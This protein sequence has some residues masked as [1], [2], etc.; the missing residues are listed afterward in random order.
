MELTV[1]SIFAGAG[2]SSLGYK[3]AGFKELLAIEWDKN[4]VETFKLNFPEVPVWQRDIREV[5]A[6]EILE[7]CKIKKGELDVLDGSPPCQG[8]STAGKRQ[9]SDERNDLFLPYANLIRGLQ[10]KIFVME[11]VSGLIKGKMKGKFIEIMIIL[12][13][14]DY[15]VKCKLMNA[16]YYQVPQSRERLIWIGVRKD[17]GIKPSYSEPSKKIIMIREA[18]KNCPDGLKQ[19]DFTGKRLELSKKI[20]RW[21]CGSDI[22]TGYSFNLKRLDW[23]KPSRTIIKQIGKSDSNYGGGLIHPDK[24]RHLTIPELKR[25]ATFPDTFHFIGKFEEQWAR[26]GNSV[27]PKMM[28]AIARNIKDKI[29]DPSLKILKNGKE[30]P[31]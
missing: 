13:S 7:F 11:N 8:F 24:N 4:A 22:V 17:L 5:K 10:P 14:L 26:I 29:L 21:G 3:Q 18:F 23:N 27:P 6:D 31:T 20:R 25:I 1:I 15:Q 30:L 16:K 9:V 28:E 12:K 2:G 19:E